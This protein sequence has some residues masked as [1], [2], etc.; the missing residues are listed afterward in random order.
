MG[1]LDNVHPG[2]D[3]PVK[4]FLRPYRG[5]RIERDF[6]IKLPAGIAKGDHRILLSDAD[7]AIHS[8]AGQRV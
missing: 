4:V 8:G 3:V 6:T 7:T 1:P 5:G 2:D